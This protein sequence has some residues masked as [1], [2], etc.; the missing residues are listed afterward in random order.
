MIAIFFITGFLVFLYL[1][2]PLWLMIFTPECVKQTGTEDITGVSLVLLSYNGKEYLKDKV[3]FLIKEL[4][5]FQHAELIIID[6]NSTDGSKEELFSFRG[7]S[8]IKII[9]KTRRM[10]IP[11]SMNTAVHLAKFDCIVFC[12]QRQKLSDQIIQRLVQPLKY[13]NVGAVSGCVY[14][15]DQENRYSMI[16]KLENFIKCKESEA[17]SLIG[18]YGPLYAI[19]KSCYSEIPGDIILDDLY[20]SL[21]ILTMKHILLMKDCRIIDENFATLND[22]KRA[23]RYLSGFFQILKEKSIIRDL[24]TKQKIMLAWHKYLRLFIP[25]SLFLCYISAGILMF[26]EI[27][28]VMIFSILTS[29]GLISFIP[30]RFRFK[31][32]VRVNILY[33]IALVD[34]FIK[35]I[36]L[37]K[38]GIVNSAINF[39]GPENMESGIQ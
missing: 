9:S 1:V 18:V 21:R 39:S 15:L 27:E 20:L 28:Y 26:R 11:D 10:G 30:G 2:Y 35:D 37:H 8:N 32:L 25:V 16:R 31:N 36:L 22:Y 13:E 5:G 38:Q 33:F 17:G 4:S 24:G 23:R 14:H 12:D 3:N 29:L 6:D 34:V 7:N 19:K